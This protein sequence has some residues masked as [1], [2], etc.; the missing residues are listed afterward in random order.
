MES[1]QLS[2]SIVFP[3]FLSILLGYILR[4]LKVWA[5]PTIGKVSSL[6]YK[7]FIPTSIFLSIYRADIQSVFSA[8]IAIFSAVCIIVLFLFLSLFTMYGEKNPRKRGVMIQGMLQSNYIILGMPIVQ[9]VYGDAGSRCV[10]GILII[11]I[12]FFTVF[13]S[14]ALELN[15]N[16]R[17]N[18][19]QIF[20][21][22]IKNPL[23]I[24]CVLGI[25]CLFLKFRLPP[26]IE[27]TASIW[28]GFATHMALIALGGSFEFSK[29]G[30]NVKQLCTVT[31]T[32]LVLIPAIIIPI[33]L[34][35]DFRNVE[36]MTLMV[37]FATPTAVSTY[38][39]AQNMGGDT[40]LAGNI[41]VFTSLFSMITLFVAIFI[42][43]Y[44]AFI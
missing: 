15:R 9:S 43:K 26:I 5:E 16:N 38:P 7:V 29:I 35:L 34:L 3:L 42:L 37:L 24:S 21:N 17:P 27:D 40:N 22:L 14:L 31:F 8:K 11:A 36:L 1:L 12:P 6:V 28:G 25:I 39:M 20:V 23:L 4:I 41:V 33:A 44:F 18:L 2:F 30:K 10:I 13:S 32:K 19:I